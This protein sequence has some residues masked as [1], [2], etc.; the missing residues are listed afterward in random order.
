M[1][2]STLRFRLAC[3]V[4]LIASAALAG[5]GSNEVSRTTNTEV[6]TT[7]T[8]PPMVSTT[9]STTE[10][11]DTPERTAR[12]ASAYTPCRASSSGAAQ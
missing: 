7:S 1:I 9:T 6:T 12:V 5:C 2:D 11:I 4:A 3:G 10:D 8:P